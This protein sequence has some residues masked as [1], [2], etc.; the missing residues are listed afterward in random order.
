MNEKSLALGK[1]K[2]GSN[3]ERRSSVEPV[4]EKDKELSKKHLED[5]VQFNVRHAKDHEKIEREDVKEMRGAKTK[6]LRKQLKGS[7]KYNRSHIEKHLESAKEDR[8]LLNERK[9][10]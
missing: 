2:M 5:S 6:A 9:E 3:H 10:G 4:T 8:K 1:K 7:L